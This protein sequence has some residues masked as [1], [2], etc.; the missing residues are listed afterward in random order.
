MDIFAGCATT[1]V[2]AENLGRQWIASDMA[3]RSWTMLKRRFYLTGVRLTGMTDATIDAMASVKKSKGFQLPQQWT[4]GYVIGPNELPE[5]N[6]ANPDPEIDPL[7]LRRHGRTVQNANWSGRIPKEEAKQLLINTFGP[8]CWGCGY[9][10]PQFPNGELDL[11]LLEV[12]HI[13]ARRPSEGTPGDDEL[14]NL[15]LLHPT[16]NRGKS[17]RLTL[18]G[19]REYNADNGRLL[20]NT[21]GDLVDLFE[22]QQFASREILRRGI[23]GELLAAEL[24]MMWVAISVLL[25]ILL[26]AG[27]VL[28]AMMLDD[29][30]I[31]RVLLLAGLFSLAIA[32]F[33]GV[34]VC[35]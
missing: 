10:P 9:V 27:S 8:A 24:M 35:F 20:I 21:V 26:V 1:A 7:L 13:R 29:A 4:S 22:A 18:E 31:G 12:D 5:R 34:P 6:D 14:Y 2:A 28:S 17:N 16:C 19:L 15:A 3:Y 33:L 23:Q 25:G 32:V 11:T 30:N